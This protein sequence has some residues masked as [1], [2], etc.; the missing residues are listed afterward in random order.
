MVALILLLILLVLVL[1]HK[2]RNAERVIYK[3]NG[4]KAVAGLFT[5]SEY[6]ASI[7]TNSSIKLHPSKQ[8]AIRWN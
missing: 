2:F 5:D 8:D 6:Y 7:I 4:Q 1:I 3:S